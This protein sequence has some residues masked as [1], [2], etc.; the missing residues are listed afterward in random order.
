MRK[1]KSGATRNDADAKIDYEG[2]LH[3]AVLEVYGHYM[4]L[5]RKQ[6]DGNLRDSDNWQKG[7]DRTVYM[8]SLLRHVFDLWK[9]HRGMR[10]ISVEDGHEVSKEEACSA[11][12]FNV[13]GYLW[14]LLNKR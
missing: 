12:L 7:I 3:P 10:V 11:I 9:L 13:Q 1:F 6:A 4:H 2:F 5:H 8:K 14:E